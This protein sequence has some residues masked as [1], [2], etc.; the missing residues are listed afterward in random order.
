MQ[1]KKELQTYQQ[2]WKLAHPD[3][4]RKWRLAHPDYRRNWYRLHPEQRIKQRLYF[5]DWW[6]KTGK[7]QRKEKKLQKRF[8]NAKQ[9]V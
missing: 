7:N 1:T 9:I 8:D 4:L 3:Y 5:H 6:L 2:K